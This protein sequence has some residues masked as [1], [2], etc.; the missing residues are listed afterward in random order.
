LVHSVSTGF[1]GVETVFPAIR[2]SIDYDICEL[3][4]EETTRQIEPNET[5]DNALSK[6]VMVFDGDCGFCRKWIARWQ[7]LTGDRVEYAPYQQATDRFPQVAEDEFAKAV[8]FIE[9]DGTTCRAA[10]AVFRSLATAPGKSWMLW[11]YKHV[12]L[13]KPV[14]ERAYRFVANHRRSMAW[15]T[16]LLW[17]NDL[18]PSTYQLSRWLTLRLLGVVYFIAFASLLVQILG[19][20]GSN[21][22]LPVTPYLDW[23]QGRLGDDAYWRL[24]TLFWFDSSDAAL[25]GVCYAGM[26]CSVL[27]TFRVAPALMLVAL[28]AMYLSLTSVG[29]VFLS[30]QW[31]AL[32]LEVGF[33]AIFFAPWRLWPRLSSESPPSRIMIFL[34]R[35]LAFR[36]IFLSGLVKLSYGDETWWNLTA[37]T[38]HYETQPLPAWTAWYAHQLPVWFHMFCCGAT[39][40]I[41]MILPFLFFAPRR[42]RMFAGLSVVFLMIVIGATGNYNFFNLLTV[43]L[44]IPLFDDRFLFRFI[45]KALGRCLPEHLQRRHRLSESNTST[46]EQAGMP[47]VRTPSFV[48]RSRSL[49]GRLHLRRSV[50]SSSGM[51]AV[52]TYRSRR[53]VRTIVLCVLAIGIVL[54]TTAQGYRGWSRG[55]RLPESIDKL[56]DPIRPFRS[57]NSY[58]LFRSMTTKRPEIVI[59]GSNDGREWSAYEFHWKP[60]DVM[61]RPRFVQPHQPRLDWQMWFAALGNIQRNRWVGSLMQRMLEGSPEVLALFE[62]NPFPDT[63]PR[64]M[65]A[66]LYDYHFTGPDTRQETGA[67]WTRERL[68]TYMRPISS[69]KR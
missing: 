8:H 11:S 46:E 40:A 9:P 39:Y 67:W 61:R 60:G 62:V 53:L 64:Y 5:P 21:G 45:P 50:A 3:G 36:L 59:E 49:L 55:V 1:S 24:P 57:F 35:W 32:L 28:W 31:D 47:A 69:R 2:R 34:F 6:A 12:P 13:V 42:L 7:H 16:S 54:I 23:V 56:I 38:Y 10:H 51:P 30:F 63:P 52:R 66:V 33:L 17:G 43:V 44:C 41:E 25:R 27:L 58:G 48:A 29:R 15:M 14:T 20:I 18:S 4:H 65:R 19:L 22:I 68:G 26:V 37:L